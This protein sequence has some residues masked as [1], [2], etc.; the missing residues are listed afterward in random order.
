MINKT[1]RNLYLNG[2]LCYK[3]QLLKW[4]FAFVGHSCGGA[5]CTAS[6]L[7]S[8]VTLNLKPV[9]SFIATVQF[10]LCDIS[11]S[12][13][14]LSCRWFTLQRRGAVLYW[15]HN[16]LSILSHFIDEWESRA[17][18][19]YFID[20]FLLLK[21]QRNSA[22]PHGTLLGHSE[23]FVKFRFWKVW[24]TLITTFVQY[25]ERERH[26][27]ERKRDVF[28]LWPHHGLCRMPRLPRCSPAPLQQRLDA[29]SI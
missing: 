6:L 17:L 13:L 10:N 29:E 28:F 26:E 25:R 11:N 23:F 24:W 8:S 14:T 27:R 15:C 5:A 2:F 3:K 20:L 9:V 22:Q 12:V 4:A 18:V 7:R 19:I 1:D 16:T 21:K